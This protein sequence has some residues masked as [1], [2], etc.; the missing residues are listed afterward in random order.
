[1]LLNETEVSFDEAGK[2]VRKQ[3]LV[4]RVEDQQGVSNW[5]EVSGRWE[6]WHQ[7]RPEIR[8]RVISGD[9]SEHW[10]DANTLNDFPVRQDAPEVYSDDRK[11]GGPLPAV[12]PGAIVEQEV[13]IRD[14]APLAAAGIVERRVFA[15]G[16][17]VHKTRLVLSHPTSLPLAYE[18]HNLP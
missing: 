18:T 11:Y 1:V 15:W 5:S 4:Y 8:A 17:P 14:T 16:V 7:S 9:G 6:A 3:R 10:L 13:L 12:A 2:Q